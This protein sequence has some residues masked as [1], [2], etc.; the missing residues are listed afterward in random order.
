MGP[1]VICKTSQR[2]SFCFQPRWETRLHAPGQAE[3]SQTFLPEDVPLCG[4]GTCA[5]HPRGLIRGPSLQTLGLVVAFRCPTFLCQVEV[6]SFRA[7]SRLSPETGTFGGAIAKAGGTG[8][9]LRV[10][11]CERAHLISLGTPPVQRCW[12]QASTS[13]SSHEPFRGHSQ[14]VKRVA[15]CS[16]GRTQL[17]DMCK[18]CWDWDV[19]YGD[20][21]CQRLPC[22]FCCRGRDPVQSL[23]LGTEPA[24]RRRRIF[25]KGVGAACQAPFLGSLAQHEDSLV[26]HAVGSRRLESFHSLQPVL[27]IVEAPGSYNS[28]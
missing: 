16:D 22:A 25:R 3:R 14:F 24:A 7:P 5:A 10:R 1:S 11:A 4:S 28:T 6:G 20:N 18:N 26:S 8:L 9:P 21:H 19:R 17:G 2:A 23:F 13:Q 27:E 15:A 12:G